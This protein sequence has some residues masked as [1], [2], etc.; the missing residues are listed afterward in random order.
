MM[1]AASDAVKSSGLQRGAMLDKSATIEEFL[2]AAAA[3]QPTPGGGSAAALTGALAASMGEMVLNYS[4]AKK[5]LENYRPELTEALHEVRNAR[6]M[7][8]QLMLEDQG[9][10]EAM[11]AAKKLPASS[12][13]RLEAIMLGVR[14]P[15]TIAGTALA[16]LELAEKVAGKVN[17][18]LLSDLAVCAELSMAAARSAIYNVRVNVPEVD[19]EEQKN[20]E[21]TCATLLTQ[22]TE[23]IK[24]VIP[25]IMSRI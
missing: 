1:S 10:Y 8:T 14:V 19:T 2:N 25:A 13:E 21:E 4:V 23:S 22:S 15:M 17:P 11:S 7:M 3:K 24:R 6:E 18:N 9:A 20:I 16:I 5:G 12:P